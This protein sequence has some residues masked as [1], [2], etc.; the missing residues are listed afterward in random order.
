MK[1]LCILLVILIESISCASHLN[2][3]YHDEVSDIIHKF[4]YNVEI[5]DFITSD[6]Y[7]LRVHRLRMPDN[8]VD[9]EIES[10]P[11][12]L[13]LHGLFS[14]SGQ[15]V[16]L[17]PSKSLGFF[18]VNHGYDVWMG[19]MRG[20]K[21]GMK[22]KYL[23]S[24]SQAFWDFDL[25]DIA[26]IDLAEQIDFIRHETN[27]YKVFIVGVAVSTI[28]ITILL[29]ER[30]EYNDKIVQASFLSPVLW[31]GNKHENELNT[32]ILQTFSLALK[33]LPYFQFSDFEDFLII[34]RN[35]FCKHRS[36]SD[37]FCFELYLLQSLLYGSSDPQNL[38]EMVSMPSYLTTIYLNGLTITYLIRIISRILKSTQLQNSAQS[39]YDTFFR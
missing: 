32:L 11:P 3:T 25:E 6:G 23:S 35:N 24:E 13:L 27:A 20:G 16:H 21:Y 26:R 15:F 34:F 31:V 22:H 7:I 1:K 4:G 30:P 18:L 12:V 2:S 33:F 10:K 28:P 19:S 8:S 9:Y 17:G 38:F 29:C 5:H 37:E 39:F 14:S 36:N